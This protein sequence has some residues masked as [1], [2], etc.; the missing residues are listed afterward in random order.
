[1][2]KPL[3]PLDRPPALHHSVQASLRTYIADNSLQPGDALPA[4]G[5]LARQLGVSRNSVR[6]GV[7][8]LESVGLLEVR[9]G[10]GVFVAAFSLE[11]LIENL[12]VALERSLR[13]VEEILEIRRALE[14]SLIEKAIKLST[15]TD[16]AELRAIVERMKERA[17]KGESFAEEDRQFHRHL[18]SSLDNAML[19][20][21]I[22]IFWLVFY[23]VSGFGKLENPDPVATCRAHEEIIDAVMA[24]D[25]ARAKDRLDRHYDGISAVVEQWRAE[26][27]RR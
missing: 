23:R 6:E 14:V 3:Q 12:P 7:K 15:P 4:E 22:E 13:H 9:R 17:R 1:M 27:L 20:S 21:L 5:V 11:P 26:A 2:A 10:I 19:L 25:A 8:A 18:F 24:G 16:L